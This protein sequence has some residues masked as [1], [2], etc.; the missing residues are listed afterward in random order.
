[1]TGRS[2]WR[3]GLT[4]A[5]MIPVIFVTARRPAP[6]L[7]SPPALNEPDA[8]QDLR[9]PVPTLPAAARGAMARP[10]ASVWLKEFSKS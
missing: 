3:Q 4:E 9:N 8:R 7:A 1:M 6:A 10:T 5:V 2:Y